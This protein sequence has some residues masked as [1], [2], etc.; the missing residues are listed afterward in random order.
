MTIVDAH[1]H[2]WN[3]ETGSYPWLTPASG[4]IFRTFEPAELL[5]QLAAAGVERTVLVQAMD[6]YADTDAM[7][8]QADAHDVIGAVVGWVPL[9]RPGEAAEALERYRRHPKFAGV[10]H[11]IHDEP[12]PDWVLRDSVVEGLR[13]L[14]AA[15]LPFDVVAVLPRHL[16]HVPVLAERV[17]GLRMVIDHLAKP[18]IKEKGWEPWASLLARAAECPQVYAKV[19]GLNTAADA[20]TWTADDLRPYVEH[21]LE[22]FGPE[23]LM[24]GS[25]WPV[26]LLAGDYAKV[27]RET[28]AVLSGLPAAGRAAV[29]GGTATRF[30]GMEEPG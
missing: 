4:P 20:A 8:A 13:L 25:D 3:L 28:G 26:A 22:S 7:L 17:P 12:D 5:P 11:L 19:S 9:W 30:Y 18:P 15:G 27:W 10:R 2:F 29:L 16:E 23:R 1:Q 24:F 21:A 14:A 6:S